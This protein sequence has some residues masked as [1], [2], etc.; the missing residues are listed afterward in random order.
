MYINIR[1]NL[2]QIPL[3]ISTST[4]C[5]LNALFSSFCEIQFPLRFEPSQPTTA[6]TYLPGPV[7]SSS[8]ISYICFAHSPFDSSA[9]SFF[10]D[11][12]PNY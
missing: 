11:F 7:S 9:Q 5:M 1:D 10:L 3:L 4:L 6:T 8:D 12:H 2:K